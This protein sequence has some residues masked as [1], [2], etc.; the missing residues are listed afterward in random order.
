[1]WKDGT[2]MSMRF[3]RHSTHKYPPPPKSQRSKFRKSF[4]KDSPIFK[5]WTA[6]A[7]RLL[8]FVSRQMFLSATSV[9]GSCETLRTDETIIPTLIVPTADPVTQLST[10]FRTIA[11]TRRWP[12]GKCVRRASTSTTIRSTADIMHSPP[13]VKC[14]GQATN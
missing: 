9:C 6:A 11:Q 13:P 4:Q 14:V 5:S 10:A 7:R 1:M 2:R 3:S 12:D 8:Q